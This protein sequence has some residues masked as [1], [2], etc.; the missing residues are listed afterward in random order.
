MR[1]HN[2]DMFD[3]P[4]QSGINQA[5]DHADDKIPSWSDKAFIELV[6]YADQ[7]PYDKFCATQV[8]KWATKEGLPE[9]PSKLA[10]GGVFQR[11]RR[12]GAIVRIC[13][14]YFNEFE[15]ENTHAQIVTFWGKA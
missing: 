12:A 13:S 1:M 7:H 6:R 11:A 5:I 14:D 2:F 15:S 10:W 8:R 9:P 3:E 4:T